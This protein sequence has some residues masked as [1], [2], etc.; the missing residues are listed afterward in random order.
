MSATEDRARAVARGLW[1]DAETRARPTGDAAAI[2]DTVLTQLESGLRRW[3]GAEGYAALLSRSVALTMPCQPILAS[4]ADLGG[5][6]R[7]SAGAASP[8]LDAVV[9]REAVVALLVTMMSQLGAIIGAPMAIDL[10]ELSGTATL[11]ALA[12]PDDTEIPS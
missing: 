3:V 6:D 11:R 8:P 9:G 12:G 10:I 2:I 5:A 4:I 1:A 7:A